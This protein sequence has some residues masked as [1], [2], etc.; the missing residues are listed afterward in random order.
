[1]STEISEVGRPQ[2]RCL[3]RRQKLDVYTLHTHR[4]NGNREA[5]SE[6]NGE[7]NGALI[8]GSYNFDC[9]NLAAQRS[10]VLRY[11][12]EAREAKKVRGLRNFLI[13]PSAYPLERLPRNFPSL[14][15]AQSFLV[16]NTVDVQN[17]STHTNLL[18][19]VST[20]VTSSAFISNVSSVRAVS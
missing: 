10:K 6:G 17:S 1:M 14:P 15:P 8:F 9:D 12:S 2:A 20:P 11:P 5:S 7:G 13:H 16:T 3:N 4:L 18:D 19:S